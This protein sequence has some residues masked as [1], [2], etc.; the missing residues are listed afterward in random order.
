[1]IEFLK[2]G[3]TLNGITMGMTLNDLYSIL[4]EPTNIYGEKNIGYVHYGA[5][6]YGFT[7]NIIKEMSIE[8]KSIEKPFKFKN[9]EYKKYD[10]SLFENFK[11]KSKSKIHKVIS[12]INHLQLKWRSE[13]SVDKD[14]LMLKIENG[15]YVVFN[16]HD[17]TI[18]RITVVD[19]HQKD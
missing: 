14:S 19:G 4:G 2:G 11:I 6:R 13:N 9:L 15:P 1:M 16:L 3:K 12:F 18:D 10:I 5:Y 17:G 8:F 7:D